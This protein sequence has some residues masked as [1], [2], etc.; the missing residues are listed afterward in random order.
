MSEIMLICWHSHFGH[1][2]FW[3]YCFKAKEDPASS[4]PWSQ[5][6]S[7]QTLLF[8][9]LSQSAPSCACFLF[10]LQESRRGAVVN[11]HMTFPTWAL[12]KPK[13]KGM[14]PL[15]VICGIFQLALSLA[16]VVL[17][18]ICCA[19]TAC[20][21]LHACKCCVRAQDRCMQTWIIT[22]AYFRYI[23]IMPWTERPVHV[24]SSCTGLLLIAMHPRPVSFKKLIILPVFSFLY[25]MWNSCI[26]L[27]CTLFCS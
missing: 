26:V 5:E 15:Q 12:F 18:P 25:W 13:E 21:V 27:H 7:K 17:I 9:E 4:C 2:E 6:L 24:S 22:L 19:V 8:S 20:H 23:F 11:R 1:D 3:N 14:W 10:A 16:S